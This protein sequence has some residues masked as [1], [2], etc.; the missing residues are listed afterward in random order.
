MTACSL[1]DM[2]QGLQ[3]Y[4]QGP[5]VDDC[6]K[7]SLNLNLSSLG[8][9]PLSEILRLPSP[10]WLV[11]THAEENQSEEVKNRNLWNLRPV[12]QSVMM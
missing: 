10:C 3:A 2:S 12:G 8:G 11:R 6:K 4:D 5:L 7:V 9:S 1:F